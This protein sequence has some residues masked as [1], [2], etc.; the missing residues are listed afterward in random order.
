MT[1]ELSSKSGL[2][3]IVLLGVVS[4]L[5]DVTYEGARSITGPFLAFLGASGTV[6]GFTAGFGELVG[7][8]LRLV[9]G[10]LA[11]RTGR[12]WLITV[13]GYAVNLLAVP[14][15]A[16]AGHWGVAACLMIAERTG[17]AIRSPARDAMLSH[18]TQSVG[19][20]WGFGL[21]EAMDQIGAVTGPLIVAL[22]LYL[23]GGF[24][25]SF[26][27]LLVPALLALAVLLAARALYPNPRD[28]EVEVPGL[29][30]VGYPTYFWIYLAAAGLIAAGFADFPLIAYHFEKTSLASAGWIP[31]FYAA[32][33][34]VDALAALVCGRFFDKKGMAVLAVATILSAFFAPLVFWGRFWVALLGVCLWGIGMGA[35]E[36][37]MRA[38]VGGMVSADKRGSA[39]GIFNAG[40]GLSWF[41]GSL[42]MG[43]LY[44]R[45]IPALVAFSVFAQLAAVPILMVVGRRMRGAVSPAA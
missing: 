13:W 34:G 9:S 15:L 22:V 1:N 38:A 39:Y 30:T 31:V 26:A 2:K 17:K 42:L 20:G 40:F 3:F 37:I 29:A 23:K 8:G 18:A 19:R 28:L 35:G 41:A 32:A 25:M 5:A 14:L 4:L 6:V 12:Y 11:D 44:D 7:Y 43:R 21:H 33:M 10:R 45:S 24:R 36:S 16:L 27:I